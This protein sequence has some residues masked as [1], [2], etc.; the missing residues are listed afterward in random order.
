MVILKILVV[1]F[2]SCNVI[3]VLSQMKEKVNLY[4]RKRFRKR[5]K[6][7]ETFPKVI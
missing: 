4:L 2:Y 1:W 7:S 6:F 5:F 3:A